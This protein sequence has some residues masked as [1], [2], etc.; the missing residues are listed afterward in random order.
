M[1]D[2]LNVAALIWFLQ[3]PEEPCWTDA[4][5]FLSDSIDPNYNQIKS[6]PDLLFYRCSEL[7]RVDLCTTFE[8]KE[9]GGREKIR[10]LAFLG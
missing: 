5:G 8:K 1:T 4:L 6:I 10:V 2:R 7:I 3:D 9:C